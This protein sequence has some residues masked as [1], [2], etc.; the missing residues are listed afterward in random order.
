MEGIKGAPQELINE[1]TSSFSLV[2]E[3]CDIDFMPSHPLPPRGVGDQE[4][5]RTQATVSSN[6]IKP[7]NPPQTVPPTG[8]Q[9]FK[10]VRLLGAS[11]I[12]ITK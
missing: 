6:K 2:L 3:V 9:M 8:D 1:L 7:T 11:L 12:Q 10:S 5:G 4:E